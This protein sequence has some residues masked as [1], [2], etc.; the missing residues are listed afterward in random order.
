[1]A[2]TLLHDERLLTSFF[3]QR[4]C[5]PFI[6][7]KRIY[8]TYNFPSVCFTTPSEMQAGGGFG[9]GLRRRFG[10]CLLHLAVSLPLGLRWGIA[11]LWRLRAR[12]GFKEIPHGGSQ[13]FQ[14]LAFEGKAF[15]S[16]CRDGFVCNYC[17]HQMHIVNKRKDLN[18]TEA[19]KTPNGLAALAFFI[20]VTT[21]P[22]DMH[23]PHFA[24]FIMY[25]LSSRKLRSF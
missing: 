3:S 2:K 19:V 16:P 10:T 22:S 6:S 15:V 20:E 13:S 24:H 12:R 11:R 25:T 23:M 17:H 5:F 7:L 9:G 8:R 4:F 14:C 18:L 1:M 21:R